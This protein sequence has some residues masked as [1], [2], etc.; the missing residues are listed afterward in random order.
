M[1]IAIHGNRHNVDGKEAVEVTCPH[2]GYEWLEWSDSPDYPYYCPSCKGDLFKEGSS[3]AIAI[4][5]VNRE[6]ELAGF[7]KDLQTGQYVRMFTSQIGSPMLVRNRARENA[8]N[9]NQFSNAKYDLDD[10]VV[11]QRVLKTVCLPWKEIEVNQP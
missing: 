9:Y 10:V 6:E 7:V 8:Q 3:A 11:K 1:Y 4:P 5:K 2:C